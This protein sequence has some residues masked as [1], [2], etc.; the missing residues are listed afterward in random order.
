M[1]GGWSVP[2]LCARL[3][4]ALR[5]QGDEAYRA[6]GWHVRAGFIAEVQNLERYRREFNSNRAEMWPTVQKSDGSDE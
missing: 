2:E 4:G 5:R 6:G 3:G 1:R